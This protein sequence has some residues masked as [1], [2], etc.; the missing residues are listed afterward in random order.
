MTDWH[1]GILMKRKLKINKIR[2]AHCIRLLL[3]EKW[4]IHTTSWSWKKKNCHLSEAAFLAR[5]TYDCVMTMQI[6]FGVIMALVMWWRS[7]SSENN[8]NVKRHS[9]IFLW[10]WNVT[11][12]F[13][14][15][16]D[17]AP[18]YLLSKINLYLWNVVS[19]HV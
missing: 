17:N 1:H 14:T 10:L 5:K 16:S 11:L 6:F 3:W 18:T 12:H 4:K 7:R 13:A 8:C 2:L 19:N 9:N 15:I